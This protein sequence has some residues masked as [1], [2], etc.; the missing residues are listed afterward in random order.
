MRQV[1]ARGVS[2]T[3]AQSSTRPSAINI[4]V[5][6]NPSPSAQYV[7]QP[8]IHP[9]DILFLDAQHG[10]VCIPKEM[11]EVVLQRLPAWVGGEE[12]VRKAVADGMGLQ[13]ALRRYRIK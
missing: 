4:P 10:C 6:L 2:A 7:S 13:E 8:I 9:G 3:S 1:L 12:E 5:T 11:V